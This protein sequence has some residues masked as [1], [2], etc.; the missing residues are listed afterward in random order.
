MAAYAAAIIGRA[1]TGEG[2]CLLLKPW[3]IYT[4]KPCPYVR[5]MA[6]EPGHK[7]ALGGSPQQSTV[8]W[9]SVFHA[10]C[11]HIGVYRIQQ[12]IFPGDAPFPEQP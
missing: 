4:Q 2:C 5:R 9:R 11:Q 7:R 3:R 1:G 8:L 6:F 12:C 10:F